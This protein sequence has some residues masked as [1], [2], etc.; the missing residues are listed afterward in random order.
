MSY[1][2]LLGGSF[3]RRTTRVLLVGHHV[4]HAELAQVAVCG[5]WRTV[6]SKF[7]LQLF[8]KPN[9]DS[10]EH[11]SPVFGAGNGVVKLEDNTQ[12]WNCRTAILVVAAVCTA[13]A[14]YTGNR[15]VTRERVSI[16][17]WMMADK[18]ESLSVLSAQLSCCGSDYTQQSMHFMHIHTSCIRSSSSCTCVSGTNNSVE[19]Y[20]NFYATYIQ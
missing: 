17:T 18:R 7:R 16:S 20:S 10:C 4:R 8:L 1:H 5:L 12:F 11:R 14:G 15:R 13:D 9:S 3:L 19:Q 6:P 2:L